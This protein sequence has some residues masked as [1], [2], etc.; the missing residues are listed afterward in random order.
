MNYFDF[1]NAV[2]SGNLEKIQQYHNENGKLYLNK[3]VRHWHRNNFIC[4]PLVE[5]FYE[6]RLEVARY[7]FHHGARLDIICKCCKMTPRD[8][9]P[10]G[11]PDE[12][13]RIMSY[14][15]FRDRVWE[16]RFRDKTGSFDKG[17]FIRM[18]L[19]NEPHIQKMYEKATDENVFLT[20]FGSKPDFEERLIRF[21]R[22]DYLW[23][24]IHETVYG[25][26]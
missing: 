17:K 18:L 8:L 9:M 1:H 10:E 14:K 4:L 24:Y 11:F 16:T 25:K 23:P 15:V 12:G 7:L 22:G 2:S 6:G 3:N 13:C 21:R 19:K 20:S 5:A 26:R